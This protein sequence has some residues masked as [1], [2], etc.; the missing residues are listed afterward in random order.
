MSQ[1]ERK[2]DYHYFNFLAFK[3]C[4]YDKTLSSNAKVL[5]F[6]LLQ[7][8]SNKGCNPKARGNDV[9]IYKI[10]TGELIGLATHHHKDGTISH[11]Q[12]SAV[13]KAVGRALSE[14]SD[15]GYI[16]GRWQVEKKEGCPL[17]VL[18]NFDKVFLT[19][20]SETKNVDIDAEIDAINIKIGIN[21]VQKDTKNVSLIYPIQSLKES[22]LSKQCNESTIEEL[23]GEDLKEL[24]E[25]SINNSNN[26]AALEL[27]E[28]PF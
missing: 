13:S 8:S 18:L 14:L 6:H 5:Y 20:K 16:G 22:S 3:K 17:T 19:S 11:K 1:V 7:L 21:N 10:P 2:S 23:A 26:Q 9:E 27:P 15:K 12:G 4:L 28:L 24:E 25:E